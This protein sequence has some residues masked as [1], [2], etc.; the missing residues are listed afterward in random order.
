MAG[1]RHNPAVSSEAI[2]AE[3]TTTGATT[4][5]GTPPLT[6]GRKI[7]V[8]V[9]VVLATVIGLVSIM[10]VWV[11][12]QM[13]SND[14][15]HKASTQV[16]QDPVIQSALATAMVNELYANVDIAAQLQQRLPKD[17]KQ[18][19]DP[20]A[21]ALRAPATQGIEFLLSQ[22]RFQALFVQASD[23]AHEKLVNVLENKTGFGISTG[24]GVVTLNVTEL[25]KQVGQELGVPGGALDKLP[26]DAGM[27]TIMRSDQLSSAQT[28]VRITK[29]LSVWLL[30]LV[31]V[32][33][34][35]AIYLARGNR[36]K[37]LAHVG[38][39][40]VMIGILVLIARRVIGNYVINALV[41]PAYHKS[42]HHLWLFA[43]AILGQIGWAVILYGLFAVFGAM[44]AGPWRATTAIRR[45][46]A[47][48]L[49]QR[50]ELAW[51]AAFV[52]FLLLVLW[53]PTHAL[54]TLWGILL[55]G[56]LFA[57]GIYFLRRETLQEF[58]D[59][60][61]VPRERRTHRKTAAREEAAATSSS[62]RSPAQEIA[63]LQELK[64]KG[65][66]SDA[67]FEQAKKLVL[68]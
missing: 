17:F 15:W 34:G 45:E 19:A 46:I 16:I 49:N 62:G 31:L 54:R 11:S 57:V 35:L 7:T 52:L 55:I 36:R 56:A 12:R 21:Q 44:L 60:G 13:L 14:S 51:G 65:A 4:G 40:L 68:A 24:N 25:L 50:Q 8:W 23:I 26:A 27:I 66:I 2:T 58:P 6:R 47:P 30:V 29:A 28:A 48:V 61:L 53:G 18:L 37:T 42:G 63:H 64:E 67:E 3:P 39:A 33:Y 38:W 32:M 20:A 10:T 43:T 41:D 5:P 1:S 22:P 59:A 9:L